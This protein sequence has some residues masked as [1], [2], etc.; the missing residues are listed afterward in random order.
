[1]L[2]AV[3][4]RCKQSRPCFNGSIGVP[5]VKG[6]VVTESL[7]CRLAG[8]LCLLLAGADAD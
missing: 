4:L 6:T 3:N 8:L 2:G 5:I 1:M 7:A